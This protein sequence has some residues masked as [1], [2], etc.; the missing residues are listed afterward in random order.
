M[1]PAAITYNQQSCIARQ[2]RAGEQV[3]IRSNDVIVVH[4]SVESR[5]HLRSAAT[6]RLE[7]PSIRRPTIDGRAFPAAAA[8]AWNGSLTSSVISVPSLETFRRSLKT[9]LFSRS[10]PHVR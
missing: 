6:E 5:R 7:T 9:E 3:S 10:Y 4:V 2:K 1:Q 8:E